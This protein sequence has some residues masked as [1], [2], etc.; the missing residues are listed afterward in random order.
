MNYILW[1]I[2][3]T[4][5]WISSH[6]PHSMQQKSWVNNTFCGWLTNLCTSAGRA[7]SCS[8]EKSQIFLLE[9]F[10]SNEKRTQ[11]FYPVQINT[12]IH[13]I[14][15]CKKCKCAD[16]RARIT[17]RCWRN[18]SPFLNFGTEYKVVESIKNQQFWLR[19]N[20]SLLMEQSTMCPR[21]V[22]GHLEKW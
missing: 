6:S 22:S 13:T 12:C 17:R 19:L 4:Y 20:C 14:R 3:F 11:I 10:H 9:H 2:L 18:I 15:N 8:V 7:N 5:I 21:S 1:K 16:I